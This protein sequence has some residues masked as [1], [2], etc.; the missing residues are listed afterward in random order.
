MEQRSQL[1][2]DLDIFGNFVLTSGHTLDLK[3]L[4]ERALG[5]E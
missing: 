1:L 3:L 5:L 2:T 4:I